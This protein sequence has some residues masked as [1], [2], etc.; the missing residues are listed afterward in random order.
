MIRIQK[1]TN[2]KEQIIILCD[3]DRTDYNGDAMKLIRVLYHKLPKDT[4]EKL[5]I[6]IIEFNQKGKEHE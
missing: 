6:A 3:T 2:E 5:A 4:F 1:A